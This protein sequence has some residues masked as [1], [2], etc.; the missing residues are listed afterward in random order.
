MPVVDDPILLRQ[1]TL[2]RGLTPEQLAHVN[3]L[4]H[5]RVVA[6]RTNVLSMEQPGERI[7]FIFSGTLKVHV[8]QADG[9]ELIIFIYGAGETLGEMSLIDNTHP[10]ADVVALERSTLFWMDRDSFHE[11]RRAIP[12]INDNLIRLLSA[13]LR[14][15][16]RRLQWL[17]T[18]DVYGR[19]ARH[20]LAFAEQDGQEDSAG[21]ILIPRRLTQSDIASFVG[22]S[23]ES[24]NKVIVEY[25]RQHYIS[26]DANYRITIHNRAALAARG[27]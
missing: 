1:L 10:S 15:T 16:T 19:V 8:E 18:Q 13:R 2:F 23:R 26:V 3:T 21:Q 27:E 17:T 11:C 7:Y 24:V 5:R 4:L 25:K 6:A 14:F 20:L 9:T 12:A 22:A